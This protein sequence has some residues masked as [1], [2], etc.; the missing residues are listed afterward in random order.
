MK[1][2]FQPIEAMPL[3]LLIFACIPPSTKADDGICLTLEHKNAIDKFLSNRE[4]ARPGKVF[5]GRKWPGKVFQL[6]RKGMDAPPIGRK[7]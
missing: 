5:E 6:W 4:T 2:C 1:F 3:P 7:K